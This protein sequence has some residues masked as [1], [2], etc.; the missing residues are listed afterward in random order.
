MHAFVLRLFLTPD[1]K[2]DKTRS[3]TRTGR[4]LIGS[5]VERAPN[6]SEARSFQELKGWVGVVE[7]EVLK[8]ILIG[9]SMVV[10]H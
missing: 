10:M 1:P 8:T 9:I 3:K 2:E 6:S 5:R 4:P 7:F